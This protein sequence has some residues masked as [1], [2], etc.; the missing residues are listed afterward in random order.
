MKQDEIIELA[1]Q[2][3]LHF[4]EFAW[5]SPTKENLYSEGVSQ[6]ALEI[7]ANLIAKKQAEKCAFLCEELW[8]KGGWDHNAGFA[9]DCIKKRFL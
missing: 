2:A 7:F 5:T 4:Y 9:A 8:R 3:G 6:E 1:E